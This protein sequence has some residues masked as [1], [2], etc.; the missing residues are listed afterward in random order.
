MH[1]PPSYLAQNDNV[2]GRVYFEV[3]PSPRPV[4]QP[5]RLG[6]KHQM[7]SGYDGSNILPGQVVIFDGGSHVSGNEIE[8]VASYASETMYDAILAL[9]GNVATVFYSPDDGTTIWELAWMPGEGF[10]PKHEGFAASYVLH[11]K[12]QVVRKVQ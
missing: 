7:L 5:K 10:V 2:T 6:G 3:E 12:F 11:L 4:P 9:Y 1:N 8:I